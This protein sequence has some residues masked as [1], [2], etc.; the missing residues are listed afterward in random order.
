M[1]PYKCQIFHKGIG[2]L[3]EIIEDQKFPRVSHQRKGPKQRDEKSP[4]IHHN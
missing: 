1:S 3:N 2:D 4:K